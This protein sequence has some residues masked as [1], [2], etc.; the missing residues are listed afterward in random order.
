[1]NSLERLINSVHEVS[2]VCSVLCLSCALPAS[3]AFA[4]HSV[5]CF[6]WLARSL[7]SS[8]VSLACLVCKPVHHMYRNQVS[9]H[10]KAYELNYTA[11]SVVLWAVRS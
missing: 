11:K 2:F 3:C 7:H 8:K 1:M 6:C 10:T 4:M 9:L 5:A